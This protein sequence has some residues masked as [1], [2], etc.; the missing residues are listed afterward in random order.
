MSNIIPI[1]RIGSVGYLNA[2]PLVWGLERRKGEGIRLERETPARCLEALRE[3]R[4][5]AGLI[6]AVGYEERW[7]AVP[8]V[9]IASDG[10]AESV[11]LVGRVEAAKMERIAL[12]AASRAAAALLKI[13]F[14]ERWH[15]EPSFVEADAEAALADESF[16]GALVIGDAALHLP[17]G[18]SDAFVKGRERALPFPHIYGLGAEWKVLTGLPFVFAFWAGRP[19]LS[20]RVVRLLQ[21]AKEEGREHVREIAENYA[22]AHRRGADTYERYLRDVLRYDWTP[23]EMEGLQAF[24][25]LAEQH[26]LIP[27]A[28]VVKCYEA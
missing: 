3:D 9:V 17:L 7:R 10:A 2:A 15:H 21:N 24:Y 4:M 12:D 6:P 23:R 28:P 19:D 8:G 13:L 16:D 18:E 14:R 5:D 27:K 1:T 22:R 11:L 26:G 20:E 25:R